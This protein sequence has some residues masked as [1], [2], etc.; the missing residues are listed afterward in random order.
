[1][2]PLTSSPDSASPHLV[3][4][5]RLRKPCVPIAQCGSIISPSNS[6]CDLREVQN[7]EIFGS[8]N[9]SKK[10]VSG[11][12]DAGIF[13][14]PYT[15]KQPL[16]RLISRP[17]E[18]AKPLFGHDT[19]DEDKMKLGLRAKVASSS[20]KSA[21]LHPRSPRNSRG[22]PS[23]H[24]P[25]HRPYSQAQPN[26]TAPDDNPNWWTLSMAART[27]WKK[28][29]EIGSIAHIRAL[30][31][32]DSLDGTARQEEAALLGHQSCGHGKEESSPTVA[33]SRSNVPRPCPGQRLDSGRGPCP[34]PRGGRM[35]EDAQAAMY[36]V[37]SRK[38]VVDLRKLE[39]RLAKQ[40]QYKE[41]ARI[42]QEAALLESDLDESAA[43]A[44]KEGWQRESKE[45]AERNVAERNALHER[46]V[47]QLW[48]GVVSGALPNLQAD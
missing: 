21:A 15:S 37:N 10:T 13:V 2:A 32:L 43:L 17:T 23:E 22:A 18:V 31:V 19:C 8:P 35:S 42:Q 1:M 34:Y 11:T 6:N 28:G 24:M 36:S 33:L 9:K 16:S 14:A 44:R 7:L 30:A 48:L 38:R 47:N 3:S 46:L 25:C 39:A 5:R 26:K 27:H 4:P 41:A 40:G 29:E 45:R 12:Q 20:S